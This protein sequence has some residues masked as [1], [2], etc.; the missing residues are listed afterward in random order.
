MISSICLM[1]AGLFELM[2]GRVCN[3]QVA[4]AKIAAEVAQEIN[5]H[6]PGA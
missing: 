6:I 3:S 1:I 2:N 4:N 5:A